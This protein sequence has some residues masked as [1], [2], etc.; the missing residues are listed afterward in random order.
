MLLSNLNFLNCTHFSKIYVF[1]L[2]SQVELPPCSFYLP[3]CHDSWIQP[4]ACGTYSSV[5][6]GVDNSK[7][8]TLTIK[9]IDLDC[10]DTQI[11]KQQIVS[12]FNIWNPAFKIKKIKYLHVIYNCFFENVEQL[13][14]SYKC[15]S[16]HCITHRKR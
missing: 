5:F 4:T 6:E 2:N 13:A 10:C 9:C 1:I 14:Q 15:T 11:F 3:P 16:I 8:L 12:I 7:R